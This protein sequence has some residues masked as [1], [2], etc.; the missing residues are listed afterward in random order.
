MVWIG[1]I[2]AAVALDVAIFLLVL[3]F[4]RK[5]KRLIARLQRA[6]PD[7]RPRK[8]PQAVK[9][10]A[11]LG[12]ADRKAPRLIRLRQRCEMRFQPGQS[13]HDLEAESVMS[14]LTPG[15]VWQAK[16]KVGPLAL[17]SVIDAY[18]EGIGLMEARLLSLLPMA[19][20]RGGEANRGE[21]MRYLAELPWA[22]DAILHNPELAW[23]QFG[24]DC[25][26]VSAPCPGGPAR[27]RLY[28][29]K[30]DIV[31][32]EAADRPRAVDGGV[33]NTPWQAR[34]WDYREIAGRRIPCRAEVAWI[35]KDGPFVY[36]R[37]EVT[38]YRLEG[39]D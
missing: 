15:F 22:P 14:P 30:G 23:H 11:Q 28:F 10:F 17:V 5:A 35:L 26:E 33:E 24:E 3:A 9:D 39:S 1:L 20:S 36:W 13:W 31:R 38:D 2:I 8:I 19:R 32:A 34:L 12:G 6:V 21:L 7:E 16:L 4:A 18:V 27:V 37:G 25:V 29:D